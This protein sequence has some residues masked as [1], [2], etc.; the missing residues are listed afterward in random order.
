[1]GGVA[2]GGEPG[3]LG[4]LVLGV[5]EGLTEFLPISSTGHLI[6]ANRLLG[7]SNP[8]YEVVIQ[9][10]AITAIVVLYRRRLAAAL[11]NLLRPGAA[12]LGSNL[13]VLLAVASVPAVVL[14]LGFGD[15]IERTL[16]RPEVVA[17][18][19]VLGG[20]VLLL[21]ER[22]QDARAA[23]G[24]PADAELEQIGWRAALCIGL[25]Q[26]LALIP[27]TSRSG[28]T[29]AGAM[30]LGY[31]RTAAAE[32]SFLLGLPILYGACLLQ[33]YKQWETMTGA[34]LDDVLIGGV[35]SFVT[36]LLIVGPFVHFLQRHTF[37]PFAWY[38]I[39][40]GGIVLLAWAS[41]WLGAAP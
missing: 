5:V 41:G 11:R 3:W 13:F 23:A 32:F 37:R 26:C 36:A 8:A 39:A 17:M 7:G 29:I 19:L 22:L 20:V 15:L 9:A 21:L 1:M 38:R 10:G 18:T 24:R 4:S 27:G 2:V 25:F 6:L 14:G 35:A 16:F 33:L 34:L 12:G 40:I 30:V 28:A 31:R